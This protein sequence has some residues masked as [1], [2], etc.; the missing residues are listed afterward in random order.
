MTE[1][2]TKIWY[3]KKTEAFSCVSFLIIIIVEGIQ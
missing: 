1:K 3:I 2:S